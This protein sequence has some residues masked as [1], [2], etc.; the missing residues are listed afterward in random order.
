MLAAIP[1]TTFPNL[2]FGFNT[3]GLMVALGVLIGA[4]IGADYA[5]RFGVDRDE[6]YRAAT[7]IVIAGIV[8]SRLTW[9]V[10]HFDEVDSPLDVIA[11][12]EGGIQF[13]GGFIAG[14][15]VGLP[16][17]LRW[18][19]VKRWNVLNGYAL[20]L[21]IGV[22]IGRIG[23]YAVGEHFGRQ[24]SFFLGTRYEGDQATLLDDVREPTLGLGS[25]APLITAN[26]GLTFHN[27]SLYELIHLVVLFALMWFLIV[28]ARR[29]G[30]EV[31]PATIAGL[32]F[33]WYAVFRFGTDTLRVNDERVLSMTGAQWM[34]LAMLPYG[35]YLLF[36]VRPQL[37]QM[38]ADQAAR[39][40]AAPAAGL[41]ADDEDGTPEKAVPDEVEPPEAEAALADDENE[42]ESAGVEAAA[43]DATDADADAEEPADE[44]VA[45]DE[46]TAESSEDEPEAGPVD[47]SDDEA[48]GD[49][50][51][52][53]EKDA[54]E[55]TTTKS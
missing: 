43:E 31:A 53:D 44:I 1:Y 22:A 28:R 41:L 33:V 37:A 42:D 7:F 9:V 54:A 16:I 30:S 29:Q 4:K 48:S 38:E 46:D 51:K 5:E 21:S 26:G 12:W 55:G 10:T 47:D 50:S 35:L 32:F 23:C 34:A 6:T 14:L 45:E 3:F 49:G 20:G 40:E 8:G 11:I 24:T 27:T 17:F 52:A 18:D 25:D 36:K 39:A 19:R 15:A 2:P 13:G